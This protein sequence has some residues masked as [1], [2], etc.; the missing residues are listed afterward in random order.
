LVQLLKGAAHISALT[1]TSGLERAGDGGEVR[2]LKG[3][4]GEAPGYVGARV[5]A[6]LYLLV[7]LI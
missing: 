5:M 1:I 7:G 4:L 2:V 3:S 6:H